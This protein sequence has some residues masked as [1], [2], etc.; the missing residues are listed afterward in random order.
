[1]AETQMEEERVPESI[2]GREAL[3][4]SRRTSNRLGPSFVWDSFVTA[5]SNTS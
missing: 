2:L 4:T 1:M 3:S 5:A